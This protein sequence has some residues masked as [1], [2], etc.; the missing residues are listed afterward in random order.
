MLTKLE[1]AISGH[2]ID[3][4]SRGFPPKSTSSSLHCI[5][6]G[7]CHRCCV[8]WHIVPK[9]MAYDQRWR[10]FAFAIQLSKAGQLG[11]GPGNPR[12][13][14]FRLT[15]LGPQG[16]WKAEWVYG[17]GKWLGATAPSLSLVEHVYRGN[18]PLRTISG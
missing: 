3:L 14:F 17:R 11:E 6:V 15:G 13:C 4:G 8:H 1:E 12:T 2:M 7:F 18:A 9:G 10:K 16:E 5:A